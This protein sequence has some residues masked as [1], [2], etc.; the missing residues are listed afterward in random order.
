MMVFG[1]DHQMNDKFKIELAYFRFSVIAPVFQGTFLDVSKAAYFRRIA[2]QPLTLPSGKSICYHSKTFAKWENLYASGGMDALMPTGRSD[3]G[4]PRC[5]DE[6]VI[7]EIYR[8]KKDFPRINATLIYHRLIEKGFINASEVSVSSVQ[9]F[10]KNNDLGSAR[11]LQMKDRKAFEEAFSTS[12]FQADTCHGPF[13]TE[14][15]IK[16]K[17]YLIMILDDCSRLIVGGRYFYNDNAYNFQCVIKDAVARYGIPHKIYMDNGSPYR[18]EQL[19]LILGSIGTVEIHCAV[20]D[21]ASK[22]LDAYCTPF[23]PYKTMPLD[24]EYIKF[25]QPII[26]SY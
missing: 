3:Y 25:I 6:S 17:T 24:F 16:R 22:E 7:E 11:L 23:A 18:N 1:G 5:L 10:I 21:G 4:K 9:R 13:I 19:S 14:N 2:E 8:L 26:T 15:G 20:R 12:M